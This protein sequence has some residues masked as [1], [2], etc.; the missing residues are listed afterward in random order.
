MTDEAVVLGLALQLH[1]DSL[2]SCGHPLR[3]TADD[4]MSEWISIE[5][6]TC[7]V[8]A[9][10]EVQRETQSKPPAGTKTF[11]RRLFS[12]EFKPSRRYREKYGGA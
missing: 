12:G 5:T 3:D 8:C 10:I 6:R 11:A 9:A 2:C 4:L 1:E 7:Q